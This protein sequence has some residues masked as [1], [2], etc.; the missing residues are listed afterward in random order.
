MYSPMSAW[1]KAIVAKGSACLHSVVDRAAT[2]KPIGIS[3]IVLITTPWCLGVF[4]V[5]LPS[6][7]IDIKTFYNKLHTYYR[8][9]YSFTDVY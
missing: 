1:W 2:P 3:D 8:K 7:R 5:I 9:L 6:P 4:S